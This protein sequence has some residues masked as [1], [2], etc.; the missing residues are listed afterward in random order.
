MITKDAKCAF[1]HLYIHLKEP[2][3]HIK[4]VKLK[5]QYFPIYFNRQLFSS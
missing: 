2:K 4:Y 5:S 3:Q 1:I